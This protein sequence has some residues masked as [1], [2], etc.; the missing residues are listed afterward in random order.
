MYFHVMKSKLFKCM[1]C[2]K[3]AVLFYRIIAGRKVTDATINDF[4]FCGYRCTDHKV[5]Y[6]FKIGSDVL[7][8]D[9]SILYQEITFEEAVVLSVLD[10]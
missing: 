7:P 1:Q 2:N 3:P 8:S 4:N 10:S 5:K 6:A 9:Y